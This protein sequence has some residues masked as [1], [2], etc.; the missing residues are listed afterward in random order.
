[1]KKED[2]IILAG[3]I[4]GNVGSSGGSIGGNRGS[5]GGSIGGSQGNSGGSSGGNSTGGSSDCIIVNSLNAKDHFVYIQELR[6]WRDS[7]LTQSLMG[8]IIIK[9][10]Y[11]ISPKLVKLSKKI[12]A[13]KRTVKVSAILVAKFV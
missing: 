11:T 5:S 9:S 7:V 1:M 10:Y 12:P 2:L 8:R 4:G 13:I 3:S 6:Q